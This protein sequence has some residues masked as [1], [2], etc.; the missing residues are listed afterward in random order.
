MRCW[1]APDA[2]RA[3]I[4]RLRVACIQVNAGTEIEPN[5]RIAGDLVRRARAAGAELIALPENVSMVVQGRQKVLARARPENDHPGLPFFR[6]L[7]RDTGAWLLA[8]SL[9][10]RL[11]GDR[12]ANRSHLVDPAGAVVASYDKIHM[13]DVDLPGGESYRESA[14]FRPGLQAVLAT[15]PWGDAAIGLGMTIC[16]DLRFP[17]LY[18]ALAQAGAQVLAVPSAFT[19]QTGQ[20]HWH[21][22]LRARAIETGCF[23]IAPAQTGEHDEGRQTYGHSLIVSPWGEVLADAGEE[24]GFIIADLDL[25]RVAAS[26]R[27]VPALRHDRSFAPPEPLRA[28]PPAAR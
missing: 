4:P 2:D 5:L 26:R 23:V 14:T 9:A 16:Y 6:D 22:L 28:G 25:A 21:V 15:L 19:R 1:P 12:V 27:A 18:R 20:A 3:V 24:V 13:F 10:I 7:A 17:Y 8:G 11:D